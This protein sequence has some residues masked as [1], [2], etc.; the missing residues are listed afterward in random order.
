M[1]SWRACPC[2]TGAVT[3]QVARCEGA[4]EVHRAAPPP[5]H[6]VAIIV[7]H[8]VQ[9]T[10]R[11]QADSAK[12]SLYTLT[13]ARA[14]E[15]VAAGVETKRPDPPKWNRTFE[16]PLLGSNQDSPDPEWAL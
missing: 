11:C 1:P 8:H 10:P 2:S 6:Q 15:T 5:D 7:P 14:G 12:S 16:L 3:W 4:R 13:P 9:L